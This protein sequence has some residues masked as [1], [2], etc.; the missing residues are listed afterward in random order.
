MMKIFSAKKQDIAWM[1]D[2]S[3]SKRSN[4]EKYQKVQNKF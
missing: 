2:L 4:Y 1:V 3:H